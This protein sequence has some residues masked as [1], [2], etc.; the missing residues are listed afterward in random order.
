MS[1]IIANAVYD[2]LLGDVEATAHT[3]SVENMFDEGQV[4]DEL[5]SN[6]YAAKERLC[7]RL[8]V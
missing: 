4:C 6:V 7:E 3:L 1:K 2:L 5:Y 8:G